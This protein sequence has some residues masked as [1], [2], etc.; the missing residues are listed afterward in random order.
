MGVNGFL[1]RSVFVRHFFPSTGSS[2]RSGVRVFNFGIITWRYLFSYLLFM[3]I[4]LKDHGN[5]VATALYYFSLLLYPVIFF[6]YIS[7]F[8]PYIDFLE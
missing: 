4:F 5:G 7:I 2:K 3:H 1:I 6:F 8:F